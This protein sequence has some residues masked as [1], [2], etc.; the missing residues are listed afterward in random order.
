MNALIAF[1]IVLIVVIISKCLCN[2]DKFSML[3]T[4]D[5]I[6]SVHATPSSVCKTGPTIPDTAPDFHVRP[7]C[8][9]CGTSRVSLSGEYCIQPFQ[10]QAGQNV[11]A[12]DEIICDDCSKKHQFHLP[13]DSKKASV[14]NGE[15]MDVWEWNKTSPGKWHQWQWDNINSPWVKEAS[16]WFR[17]TTPSPVKTMT[18]KPLVQS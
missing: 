1:I 14:I 17:N 5:D 15:L 10:E 12:Y 3:R 8:K 11:I 18:N 6:L 4:D 7:N 13:D 16:K 9:T 2:R